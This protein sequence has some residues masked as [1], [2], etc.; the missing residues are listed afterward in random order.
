MTNNNDNRR[1]KRKKPYGF[2]NWPYWADLTQAMPKKKEVLD[3][4]NRS[5][6]DH[7]IVA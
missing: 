3:I 6:A 5:Q 7:T 1:N 2:K 4:V